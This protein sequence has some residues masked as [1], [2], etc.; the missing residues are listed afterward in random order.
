MTIITFGHVSSPGKPPITDAMSAILD[1]SP[2]QREAF[3]SFFQSNSLPGYSEAFLVNA[4]ARM[5]VI[6]EATKALPSRRD[7]A[8]FAEAANAADLLIASDL[9]MALLVKR[10]L[11]NNAVFRDLLATFLPEAGGVASCD[12]DTHLIGGA[13]VPMA[14]KSLR[15]GIDDRQLSALAAWH[16]EVLQSD[17]SCKPYSNGFIG[18]VALLRE[19]LFET[20]LGRACDIAGDAAVSREAMTGCGLATLLAPTL[21]MRRRERQKLAGRT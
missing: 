20:Y 12:L 9:L 16:R 4:Y 13:E 15:D 7:T 17:Y 18:E 2:D 8:E 6:S 10:P 21:V 1:C 14:G 5:K 11:Q 3:N 19:Q